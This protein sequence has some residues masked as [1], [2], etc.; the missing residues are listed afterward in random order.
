MSSKTM[1]KFFLTE[2][3]Y[4]RGKTLAEGATQANPQVIELPADHD[5]SRRWLPCNRAAQEALARL[6]VNVPIVPEP[7][8]RRAP[9]E[10]S[11]MR[12][13]AQARTRLASEFFNGPRLSDTDPATG[14]PRKPEPQ[15]LV[16]EKK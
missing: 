2:S 8:A 10:P 5:P 3:T 11:S 13:V 1:A 12:E 15:R 4:V 16:D 9:R 6:G 7:G 14:E